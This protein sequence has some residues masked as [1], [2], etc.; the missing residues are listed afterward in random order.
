MRNSFSHLLI[1]AVL[2]TSVLIVSSSPALPQAAPSRKRAEFGDVVKLIE[3]HFR[4]R[5][6]G[7]PM[8]A[9]LPLKV[10]GR[11]RRFAELGSVKLATF[12]DQDFSAPA[13][14]IDFAERLH[15]RLQPEWQ[16]L[17]EVR[18]GQERSQTHIYTAEAGRLFKVLVVQ[19]G[20]RDATA[21]QVSVTPENLSKLLQ[22]P[23][24]MG[25]TLLDE[26]TDEAEP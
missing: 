12:E 4:V 16:P 11:F 10:A 8:L 13:G 26:T 19:I 14:T 6:K 15:G 9:K 1:I 7:L 20:R 17:I 24:T 25:S 3:S 18:S 21:L 23:E 22:S 5:H 2:F